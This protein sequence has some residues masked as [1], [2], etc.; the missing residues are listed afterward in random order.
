MRQFSH[1]RNDLLLVFYRSDSLQIC[2]DRLYSFCIQFGTVH[3]QII[4]I[5]NLLSYRA[6]LIFLSGNFRNQSF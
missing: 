5:G 1:Q 3:R 6:F 2:F 4:N